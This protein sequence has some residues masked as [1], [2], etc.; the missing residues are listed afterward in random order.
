MKSVEQKRIPVWFFFC[1]DWVNAFIADVRQVVGRMRRANSEEIF[2]ISWFKSG[3]ERLLIFLGVKFSR[4][5]LRKHI[6]QHIYWNDERCLTNVKAQG[7]GTIRSSKGI[8][9]GKQSLNIEHLNCVNSDSKL[10]VIIKR[11]NT[12]LENRLEITTNNV[13]KNISSRRILLK[14]FFGNKGNRS[15]SIWRLKMIMCSN[16][17]LAI[18]NGHYT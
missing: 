12:P 14:F 2:E 5:A 4:E 13:L 17:R 1:L 11:R 10:S 3:S 15:L 7:Y 6:T 8:D 18:S 16:Y 9:S